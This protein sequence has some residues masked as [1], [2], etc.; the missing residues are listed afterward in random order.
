MPGYSTSLAIREMQVKTTVTYHFTYTRISV[1][2]QTITSVS[3]DMEEL[4]HYY[5][6]ESK[7]KWC[8]NSGK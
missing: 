1:I 7:V 6:A 8:N 2:K 5:T 4:E 3:K